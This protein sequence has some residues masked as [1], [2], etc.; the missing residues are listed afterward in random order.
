M[1][2]IF[3]KPEYEVIDTAPGFWKT[4]SYFRLSDWAMIPALSAASIPVGYFSGAKH[5][6]GRSAGAVAGMI[7]LTGSF[8][9]GYQN[10]AGRLLGL[11][12][13]VAEA[14]ASK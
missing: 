10:A 4:V 7:G 6:V 2:I 8:L 5:G 14:A 12:E 3:G 1:A 11:N 13:N 9:L